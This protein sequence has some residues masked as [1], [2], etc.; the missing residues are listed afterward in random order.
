VT[1]LGTGAPIPSIERFSSST[2]I[3]AGSRKLL[4]DAGRGATMRLW[5]LG[6]PLSRIDRLLITHFH[7]D[8]VCGVPDL[9]LTG[10]LPGAGGG[11][12][13]P[14]LVSGPTGT[15]Q[16][17]SKLAEAYS[18][19]IAIR[20]R[21]EN[22]PPEGIASDVDEFSSDGVIFDEEGVRVLC[23]EV[24]HGEAVKPAYGYR[25]DYGGRSV[26]ISGDTCYNENVITHARGV[27]LLVHEVCC[28]DKKLQNE[29]FIQRIVAHHTS[30]REAGKVFAQTRP[31]L[32]AY[33]HIVQ[34]GHASVPPPT[35]QDIIDETRETYDGPFVIGEDLMSFEIGD[36]VVVHH[37]D[38]GIR[39]TAY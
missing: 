36:R 13:T 11:R 14:F 37:N 35:L 39:S 16:F 30:P 12:S 1:L 6:I 28:V 18:H 29:P 17:M 20:I 2:L 5:Q 7:S 26:V 23:F 15:K 4:I 33:T 10:W 24:D 27:D 22:F 3:E 38:G 32:A 9:W 8:H 25:V 21:D 19:D 34:L 31:K